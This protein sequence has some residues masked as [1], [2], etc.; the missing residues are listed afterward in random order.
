MVTNAADTGW[1]EGPS[2]NVRRVGFGAFAIVASVVAGCVT[3]VPAGA[4]PGSKFC[5]ALR[6]FN[7]TR[8]S[9][10]DESVTA[11][12]KLGSASAP[13]VKVAVNVIAQ[14]ADTV[15]VASALAQAAGSSAEST[16]L[17]MAGFTVATAADQTCHLA[18]NFAGAVPTG[19]SKRK[20]NPAGWARTVCASISAWGQ[21]VN[22]AGANL[23]T[24]A[25]GQT[26]LSDL[27]ITL[28]QFLSTVVVATE[29]LNT[30]L[31]GAGI[32]KTP[33]GDAIASSIRL[34]VSRTL[35]VFVGAQPLVSTLPNDAAAFQ[36]TAQGLVTKLDAAGRSVG[37]LVRVAETQF[38][39]PAL[40]AVV[41][42]QP[43]CAGIG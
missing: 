1:V 17:S 33:H 15:D 19:V 40:V 22:A 42:R 34:G 25:N 35:F 18:V 11:L 37:A 20:V 10:K 4:A 13:N 23:A 9:S 8:P 2:R 39:A 28:S 29:Q 26:T 30:E 3:A 36:T 24:S 43:G 31:G 14:E 7:A 41:A 21:T 32:P 27:R 5:A 38:K 12:K 6:T 16:P